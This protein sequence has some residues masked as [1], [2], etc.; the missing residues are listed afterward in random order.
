MSDR[1]NVVPGD[2]I[3]WKL[4]FTSDQHEVKFLWTGFNRSMRS[5]EYA[6]INSSVGVAILI[7]IND[8]CYTWLSPEGVFSAKRFV[9]RSIE[10][11][12]VARVKV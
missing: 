10:P 4:T 11:F 3:E 12:F 5:D 6:P 2:L 1:L 8:E 9:N 7:S